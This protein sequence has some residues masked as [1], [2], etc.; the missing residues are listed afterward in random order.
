MCFPLVKFIKWSIQ[1]IIMIISAK[2]TQK[3]QNLK[4]N[5]IK[6]SRL[7]KNLLEKLL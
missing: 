2:R 6:K 5:T 7:T 4:I 3:T 1:P